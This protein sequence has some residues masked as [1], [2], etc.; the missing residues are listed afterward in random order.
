MT[1][2][3]GSWPPCRSLW[4][5]GW[6][7]VTGIETS[8]TQSSGTEHCHTRSPSTREHFKEVSSPH[9]FNFNF[10]LFIAVNMNDTCIQDEGNDALLDIQAQHIGA[11]IGNVC[12]AAPTY[13]DDV[14]LIAS[15]E[16][17]DVSTLLNTIE[18]HANMDRLTIN[19][20]KSVVLQCHVGRKTPSVDLQS[21]GC[22]LDSEPTAT[23]LGVIQ[24]AACTINTQRIG[25]RTMYALFGAGLYGRNGFNP[26][27]SAKIWTICIRP[28]LL[29]GAELWCLN[30]TNTNIL[31]KF[32]RDRLKQLQ[33]F[34]HPPRTSSCVTLAMM[35]MFPIEA[36]I[37]R[38]SLTFFR[39]I[40]KDKHSLEFD[41]CDKQLT[42]KG[43]KSRS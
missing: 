14:A 6:F 7:F 4:N 43:S 20:S 23:H 16:S 25:T 35:G 41:I 33:D 42:V 31:E 8:I 19:S 11:I 24:G 29:H 30:N 13:A 40:N 3:F 32:Q 17:G 10:N 21:N 28:R 9:N 1:G 2:Y 36:E 37:D 12:C 34:L 5:V 39:Y 27:M 18:T 22:V 38:K 15:T 26:M